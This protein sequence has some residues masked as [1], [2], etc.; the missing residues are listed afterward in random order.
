MA[1]SAVIVLA[2]LIVHPVG[3]TLILC[4]TVLLA[5]SDWTNVPLLFVQFL[6]S[7]KNTWLISNATPLLYR[8]L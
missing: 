8:T 1:V 7:L 2:L 5:L 4:K 3:G 6:K